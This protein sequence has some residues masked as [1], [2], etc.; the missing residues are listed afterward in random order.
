MLKIKVVFQRIKG[1]RYTGGVRSSNG[2]IASYEEYVYIKGAFASDVL[3]PMS[4]QDALALKKI[5]EVYCSSEKRRK[6][7][8]EFY[9]SEY[10]EEEWIK[11][12]AD[13]L[14]DIIKG[15]YDFEIVAQE[16][17]QGKCIYDLYQMLSEAV[18]PVSETLSDVSDK[19]NDHLLALNQTFNSEEEKLIAL[20][21]ELTRELSC[22]FQYEYYVKSSSDMV[23]KLL[24]SNFDLSKPVFYIKKEKLHVSRF[25]SFFKDCHLEESVRWRDKLYKKVYALDIAFAWEDDALVWELLR[26]GFYRC[27]ILP[28][29]SEKNSESRSLVVLKKIANI[30]CEDGYGDTVANLTN[31]EIIDGLQTITD[32]DYDFEYPVNTLYINGISFS[33]DEIKRI[34]YNYGLIYTTWVDDKYSYGSLESNYKEDY[35]D[36]SDRI[37]EAFPRSLDYFKYFRTRYLI[38]QHQ[39]QTE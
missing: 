32:S 7:D 21:K 12:C 14:N 19:W 11:G 2:W 9:Y 10:E 23:R 30:E 34:K 33:L 27:Q 29:W 26:K 8:R 5:I 37:S 22:K 39:C 24:D 4:H 13:Q 1:C 31:E 20:F 16:G 17:T 3:P 6:M 36:L 25:Y 15:I 18:H 28:A 35:E 38:N